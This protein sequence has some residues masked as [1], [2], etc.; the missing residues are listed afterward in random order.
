MKP[1]QISVSIKYEMP[2]SSDRAFLITTVYSLNF[3]ECVSQSSDKE[4]LIH[5]ISVKAITLLVLLKVAVKC[6]RL[7]Q[8]YMFL[9]VQ[10]DDDFISTA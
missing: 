10:G 2:F 5:L 9:P 7:G 6:T 3:G 8:N 4:E 1:G